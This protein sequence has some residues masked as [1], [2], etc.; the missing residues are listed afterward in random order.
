MNLEEL[1]KQYPNVKFSTQDH[2]INPRDEGQTFY[3]LGAP[4]PERIEGSFIRIQNVC[5]GADTVRASNAEA[6]HRLAA[7]HEEVATRHPELV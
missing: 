4:K 2:C 1:K 7:W 5:G 3:P 6:I